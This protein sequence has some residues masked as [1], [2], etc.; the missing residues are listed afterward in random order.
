MNIKRAKTL[1]KRMLGVGSNRVKIKDTKKVKE[2]ITADDLRSLIKQKVI[3]IDEKKGNTRI[4]GK[5]NQLQREKGRR[6]GRGNRRGTLNARANLKQQ[7]IQRVRS[8]RKLIKELK[9]ENKIDAK[10]Y[11]KLYYMIKGNYFKSKSSIITYINDNNL[12]TQK[13]S[14]PRKSSSQPT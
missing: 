9:K 10:V 2:S 13:L 11:K 14:L 3:V 6:R 1:V 7:W 4:R 12:S 8:Q 5:V